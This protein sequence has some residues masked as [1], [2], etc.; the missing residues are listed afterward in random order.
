[1]SIA[2]TDNYPDNKTLTQL[3]KKYPNALFNSLLYLGVF[4]G[5][6]YSNDLQNALKA[7]HI[8]TVAFSGA[9]VLTTFSYFI[10]LKSKDYLKSER[11]DLLATSAISI[12]L[13]MAGFFYWTITNWFVFM[14]LLFFFFNLFWNWLYQKVDKAMLD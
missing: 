10:E 4:V 7:F 2:L 14:G 11:K 9:A 3:I 6:A 13:L 12:S 8:L 5:Y 1:M